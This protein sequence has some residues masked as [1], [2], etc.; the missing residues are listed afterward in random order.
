M[1]VRDRFGQH[2]VRV[3]DEEVAAPTLTGATVAVADGVGTRTRVALGG[4][5]REMNYTEGHVTRHYEYT[6]EH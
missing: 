4:V 3:H 6:I 5:V 2:L 1:F